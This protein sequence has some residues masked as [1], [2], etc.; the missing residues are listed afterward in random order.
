MPLLPT[1]S[2]SLHFSNHL[3]RHQRP[4]IESIHT[5]TRATMSSIPETTT[6][7][8]LPAIGQ[9]LRLEKTDTPQTVPP[10]S[11]VVKVLATTVRPHNRQGFAGQ[12]FLSFPLPFAPG[13]SAVARVLAVGPDAARLR[14]GKLVWVNGFVTSRDDPR[15]AQFLLGLH[16]NGGDAA[17]AP[18]FDTWKGLWR[19]AAVVPLENCLPLDE[20]VLVGAR[21]YSFTDLEYIERLAVAQGGVSAAGMRPGETVVV[22][23]ATGHYSGATAEL[24]AQ[25]GC[26]VIALTRSAAKL[27]PLAARH[28]DRIRPVEL[29]GNVDADIAL[30][31]AAL[32]PSSASGADAFIDVSPPDAGAS[33]PHFTV[34]LAAL[35]PYGR[36]VL[37]G[38]LP[39][40][41][42]PYMSLMFR[43]IS[44]R[45]QWM[46]ERQEAAHL[47]KMIESGLVRLGPEAGHQLIGGRGFALEEWEAAVEAAEKATGWGQQ[48]LFTP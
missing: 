18:L 30:V 33:P 23:P 12:G 15:D 40:V 28:P 46:Y 13:N 3:K 35:R 42:V 10:G 39:V 16:D 17:I 25:M 2:T 38:A 24:A 20:D 19:D 8:I 21:G 7:L 43:S 11:A 32:P 4:D 44:I 48:V 27:G 9:P 47:I 45:G 1:S 26:H 41:S 29:T 37:L 14:P 36:A 6:S 31:R 5:S 34:A 22:A